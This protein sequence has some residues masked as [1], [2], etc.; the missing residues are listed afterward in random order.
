MDI[1]TPQKGRPR[2]E[3]GEVKFTYVPSHLHHIVFEIV[4]NSLRAVTEYH[5]DEPSLP[6]VKVIIVKGEQDITIKISDEGGGI[7]HKDVNMLF[8]Y[9]YSTAPTPVFDVV[10]EMHPAPPCWPCIAHCHPRPFPA[11]SSNHARTSLS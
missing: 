10:G 6:P 9:L 7:P 11:T 2:E 8:S 3:R 5:E 4:K 1:I